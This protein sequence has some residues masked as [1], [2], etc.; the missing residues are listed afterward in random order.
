[1]GSAELAAVA[2]GWADRV[3]LVDARSEDDFW[4]VPAIGEI[5]APAALLIRPDGHV[6]WGAADN[7]PDVST[8][9]AA[10]TTWFGPSLQG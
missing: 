7:A 2:K 5:P 9:R 3:D 1:G 6:A 8:L 10:L 4:P